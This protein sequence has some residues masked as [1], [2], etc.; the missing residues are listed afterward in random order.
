LLPWLL[1]DIGL[2]GDLILWQKKNLIFD[3]SILSL[4]DLERS[5]I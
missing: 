4:L 3:F 2:F 1:R 5:S